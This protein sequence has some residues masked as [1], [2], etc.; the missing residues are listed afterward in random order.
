VAGNYA[1]GILPQIKA[2]A[3]GFQQNL[4]LFPADHMG[5]DYLLTEVGTMNLFC[6]LKDQQGQFELV[7]PQLDGTIL[8]GVTRDSI[9]QLAKKQA[10][11]GGSGAPL[12]VSERRLT[13]SEL[14]RASDEG[15]LVEMFG[16]GTA[17]IVSPIKKIRYV[18]RK[19]PE[20]GKILEY[21]VGVLYFN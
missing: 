16:S 9:L 1:P 10:P 12:R 19:D 21:K 5:S 15:R 4:W 7:T 6:V 13:M 3:E 11:G 2:A 17:A 14:L 20:S 8:P 18:T